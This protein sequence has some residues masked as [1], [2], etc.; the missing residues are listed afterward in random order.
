MYFRAGEC[1]DIFFPSAEDGSLGNL[2]GRLLLIISWTGGLWR[3]WIVLSC[4]WVVLAYFIT[5]PIGKIQHRN[6]PILI[7]IGA[8]TAEFPSN[9]DLKVMRTALVELVKKENDALKK[10]DNEPF[11]QHHL[12][13]RDP[14]TEAAKAL[15]NY[16]PRSVASAPSVPQGKPRRA[17]GSGR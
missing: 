16:F 1:H 11:G 3:I 9:T 5:D 14:E 13:M 2:I 6:D 8:D 15:Q 7:Y 10:S 4:L 12:P 17:S